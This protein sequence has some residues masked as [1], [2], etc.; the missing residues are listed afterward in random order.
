MELI[1]ERPTIL[2][3]SLEELDFWDEMYSEL[4]NAMAAKATIRRATKPLNAINYLTN[5]TP[6]AIIVTD[7]AI[8]EHESDLVSQK[9]VEYVRGGGTAVLATQFSNFVQWPD[10]DRWLRASW[11]LPWRA[12]NYTG[13]TVY[14]NSKG[15]AR[16]LNQSG[17]PEEY[18]QKA[19]FLMNVAKE[20][21]VYHSTSRSWE[22]ES[23]QRSVVFAKIGYGWLGYIGDVNTEAASQAALLAM[24]G[25]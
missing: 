23:K 5:N 19:L 21:A 25:L 9:V 17:L 13:V 15:P 4:V 16:F 7:P 2:L 20:A 11:D 10:L 6:D 1:S 22:T 18:E 14:L 24:C 3:L 12:G 8:V